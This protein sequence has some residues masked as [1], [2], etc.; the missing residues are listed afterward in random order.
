MGIGGRRANGCANTAPNCIATGSNKRQTR[1]DAAQGQ[2]LSR[3]PIR[4]TDRLHRP[5]T[6]CRLQSGPKT[7]RKALQRGLGR[8]RLAPP[9]RIARGEIERLFFSGSAFIGI[10]RRGP[11]TVGPVLLLFRLRAVRTLVTALPGLPGLSL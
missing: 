3:K 1:S 6:I 2:S 7:L 8:G 10:A 9:C 11:C 5:K 4:G